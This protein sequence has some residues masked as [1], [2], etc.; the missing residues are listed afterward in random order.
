M[1][2][3][4]AWM[5]A[6]AYAPTTIALYTHLV[7]RLD[8]YA[9]TWGSS[10][11]Q[12]SPQLISEW[13]AQFRP[14]AQR[15]AH[16]ALL[17]FYRQRGRKPS[18]LAEITKNP[19]PHRLPRPIPAQD[20]AAYLHMA[21][22]MGGVHAAFGLLVGHTGCRFAEAHHARWE[23]LELSSGSWYIYGKGSKRR[24]PKQRVVP[25]REDLA[26]ELMLWR[27]ACASR[28][29]VFPSPLSPDRPC[30]ESWLRARH[31][32]ILAR[33]GLPH[34]T[35]HRLRHSAASTALEATMD[36]RAVGDLLGHASVATTQLYTR[37]SANRMRAVVDALPE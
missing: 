21:R 23:H 10:A 1:V 36:L 28:E 35:P 26:A 19:E 9:R 12:A 27:R 37:V 13:L 16:S 22:R 14:P 2:S 33:A 8:L 32:E 7:R 31:A 24:G 4:R 20:Y 15:Q 25:L 11:P 30:S 29:W 17:A 5:R 3:F 6:Q 18:P 34:Y